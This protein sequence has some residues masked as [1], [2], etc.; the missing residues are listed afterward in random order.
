MEKF[1]TSFLPGKRT[2]SPLR[3]KTVKLSINKDTIKCLVIKCNNQQWHTKGFTVTSF[4]T[5]YEWSSGLTGNLVLSSCQKCS[6]SNNIETNTSNLWLKPVG[7]LTIARRFTTSIMEPLETT[8]SC[9][10][11]IRR[12]IY[13]KFYIYRW[14][15]QGI[16]IID[17]T[18]F[19]GF[20]VVV[21]VH[22]LYLSVSKIENGGG[23]GSW[24]IFP[25]NM[26]HAFP[27]AKLNVLRKETV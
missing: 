18:F 7:I 14:N 1:K 2:I 5:L 10:E 3:H 4:I 22:I 26:S 24:A 19:E 8:N 13:L 27:W 16:M 21:V 15:R 20:V 25:E 17:F 6:K 23:L 12:I 9:T 11:S